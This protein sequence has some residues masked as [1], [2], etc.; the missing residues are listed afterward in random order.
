[1]TLG[2]PRAQTYDTI[3]MTS[4]KMRDL[5]MTR[6]PLVDGFGEMSHEERDRVSLSFT[7]PN[8]VPPDNPGTGVGSRVWR[9]ECENQLHAAAPRRFRPPH[10]VAALTL[11]LF[12]HQIYRR[13]LERCGVEGVRKLEQD[14]RVKIEQK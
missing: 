8:V 7:C 5:P 14:I 2:D 4:Y 1:M 6:A 12:P 9:F 10:F 3:N 13:A 11:S